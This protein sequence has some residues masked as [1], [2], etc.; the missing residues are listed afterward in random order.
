M[1]RVCDGDCRYKDMEMK[2]LSPPDEVVETL[3]DHMLQLQ[4]MLGMGKFVE[5][6]RSKVQHWQD[7]LS[8]VESTLMLWLLVQRKWVALE[9]IFLSSKDIRSQLPEDSKRFEG[10]DQDFK[11]LMREAEMDPT[12]T[13]ACTVDGREERLAG[14]VALLER[15]E[16]ALNE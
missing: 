4:T 10:I 13:G 3:E 6:F 14:M 9:S 11:D 15:C 8:S 12:V 16:K 1:W 2:V 5:Y 7:T